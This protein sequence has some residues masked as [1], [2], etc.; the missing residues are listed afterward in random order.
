MLKNGPKILRSWVEVV[1]KPKSDA[2]KK[3][4][5]KKD[6]DKSKGDK[7][8]KVVIKELREGKGK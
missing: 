4:A 5:D 3:D 1:L 6:A 7:S 8:K 2:D